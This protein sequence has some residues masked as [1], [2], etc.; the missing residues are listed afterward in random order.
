MKK[1]NLKPM[2]RKLYRIIT[3]YAKKTQK[4]NSINRK[5]YISGGYGIYLHAKNRKFKHNLLETKDID[6]TIPIDNIN[7]IDYYINKIKSIIKEMCDKNNLKY[8]NFN[9]KKF[10]FRKPIVQNKYRK[11]VNFAW[12]GVTYKN[13]Y[14]CFDFMF[15]KNNKVYKNLKLSQKFGFPIKTLSSYVED[16]YIL[17]VK[18]YLKGVNDFA[19]KKRNP[20]YG[21]FKLKGQK[22]LARLKFL[23]QHSKINWCSHV[24][25][26]NKGLLDMYVYLMSQYNNK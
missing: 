17:L 10:T 7:Q 3:D 15:S 14:E 22:D 26:S 9:F 24:N 1:S 4:F 13:K 16:T 25:T 19:Y 6:I 21:E 12:F 23:C 11:I 8:K 18:E 5:A 20:K 2:P